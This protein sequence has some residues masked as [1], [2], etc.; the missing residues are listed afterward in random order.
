MEAR[1]A[2]HYATE[3]IR[4]MDGSGN[5]VYVYNPTNHQHS[6]TSYHQ[7]SENE[8]LIGVYGVKDM[9][10]YFTSFGFIVKVKPNN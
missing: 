2:A 8:E 5:E 1:D 10:E 3:K 6:T 4:F 9:W 7:L